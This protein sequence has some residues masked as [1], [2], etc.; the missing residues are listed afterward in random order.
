MRSRLLL[1]ALVL[2]PLGSLA[3]H[4]S[5]VPPICQYWYHGCDFPQY[6]YD[7][8]AQQHIDCQVIVTR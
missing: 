8:C 5:A 4:A 7:A 1:A 2:A 6:V 3:P